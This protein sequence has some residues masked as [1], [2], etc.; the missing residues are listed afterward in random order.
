MSRQYTP[1]PVGTLVASIKEKQSCSDFYSRLETQAECVA[2]L[3]LTYRASHRTI[4][5]A[6]ADIADKHGRVLKTYQML[7]HH[8]NT[9]TFPLQIAAIHK[10]V[11]NYCKE[12]IKDGVG[13]GYTD[14]KQQL[15]N[16]WET[17]RTKAL[18]SVL[19]CKKCELEFLEGKLMP[20]S[21]L[22]DLK[23]AV[24]TDFEGQAAVHGR[25]DGAT[26]AEE[27]EHMDE[28][29]AMDE[30]DS[31]SRPNTQH[32]QMG[33]LPKDPK[34]WMEADRDVAAWDGPR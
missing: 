12:F 28:D 5:Y 16:S 34:T 18:N 26:L 10:P 31:S 3:P 22:S 2:A 9:Q 32:R 7:R 24:S 29:E 4:F 33:T 14:H 19:E 21:Y 17:F 25:S 20:V 1:A 30:G 23:K 11:F 13:K 27:L 6:L 8:P 15:R